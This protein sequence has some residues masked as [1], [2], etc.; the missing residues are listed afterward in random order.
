MK[1]LSRCL[2]AGL[3]LLMALPAF[4]TYTSIDYPGPYYTYATGLNDSGQIV[5]YYYSSNALNPTEV[6]GFLKDGQTY[7]PVDFPGATIT[8]AY[9]INNAGQIVG[10]YYTSDSYVHGFLKDGQTYTSID[11]PSPYKD[12]Y[13][14]GIN[15]SGQ[16]VGVVNF[17]NGGY[18]GS[19]RKV[20]ETY[21]LFG[22]GPH[23]PLVV[24]GVN[25]LGDI[26]GYESPYGLYHDQR[27][28]AFQKGVYETIVVPNAPFGNP[29]RA[30][31]IND[32]GQ[33]VGGY[34]DITV[35]HNLAFLKDGDLYIAFSYPEAQ[36]TYAY[37]INNS[38]EIVGY[39]LDS[40]NHYHGF[41]FTLDT[42]PLPSTLLLLG[43]GL[44]GLARWRRLAPRS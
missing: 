34:S 29:P 5:G 12:T 44:L 40:Q 36:I 31:G 11:F 3:V 16:I 8:Y 18:Y 41:L 21:S 2:G 26:V 15:D 22:V 37:D 10:Y 35:G 32:S 17:S 13:A 23:S 38:G 1:K 14:Y 6:H 30:R 33:I 39:Y 4:A 20:G 28:F 43:S 24:Y 27:P 7:T 25:N 9:G 19:F 42:V